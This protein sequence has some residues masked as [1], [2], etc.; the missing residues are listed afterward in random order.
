[1]LFFSHLELQ[2]LRLQQERAVTDD[3][4][5]CFQSGSDLDPG[6]EPVSYLN[7][8]RHEASFRNPY[9]DNISAVDVLKARRRDGEDTSRS[10][11]FEAN[12]GVHLWLQL[13]AG[14]RQDATDRYGS[15]LGVEYVADVFKF[16]RKGT[17]A[18]CADSNLGLL[19]LSQR[20]KMSFRN[21]CMNPEHAQLTDHK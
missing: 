14:I 9:E 20:S 8:P 6:I 3:F 10:L 18:I 7:R 4:F 1:A 21:F 5:A 16:C 2:Q 11:Q 12:C 19:A 13:P 17:I 15:S